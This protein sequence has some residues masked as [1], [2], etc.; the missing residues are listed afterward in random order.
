M[1][2]YLTTEPVFTPSLWICNSSSE[3]EFFISLFCWYSRTW[4][5]N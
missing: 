5:S 1:F 2:F 4:W 3:W